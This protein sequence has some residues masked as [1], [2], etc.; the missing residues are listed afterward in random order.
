MK[1]KNTIMVLALVTFAGFIGVAGGQAYQSPYRLNDKQVE[2]I[3]HNIE[4][5]A[6]R[7]RDG[8]DKA[9]D[10]SRLNGT[11]REDE[12]NARVKEFEEATKR[13]HENFDNRRSAAG[14]V[15]NVLDRATRIDEF[16]YRNRLGGRA[17]SDWARIK[18]ELDRL[19]HAYGVSWRWQRLYPPVGIQSPPYRLNDKQ[20]ERLLRNSERAANTFRRSLDEALDRSRL[21]GSAREDNI[22]QF[23][24][25][26]N[27]AMKLL[28]D[29]F[30]G[31]TSIAGDVESVLMRAMRI[32]DF[33]RRHPFDRRVQRDWSKLRSNL[34]QLSQ[35]YNV[36]WNWNYRP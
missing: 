8:L 13:L 14:D 20:V 18:S 7:F 4:K 22:N 23:V 5:N 3:I 31:H 27:D 25:E 34:D 6:E 1:F 28:R 12:V 32:D 15:Q 24:K 26:F 10:D 17:E 16:M 21:D 35:S 11:E 19:A 33:M 36:A 30:D 29:R 9:L 2:K